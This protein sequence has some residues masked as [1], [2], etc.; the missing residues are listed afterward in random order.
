INQ[1]LGLVA[2]QYAEVEANNARMF[3]L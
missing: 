2:Q 1:A 3:Q